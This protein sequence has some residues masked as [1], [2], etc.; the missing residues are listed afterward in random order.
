MEKVERVSKTVFWDD[1]GS[2][3]ELIASPV[4]ALP[5]PLGECMKCTYM[6]ML[7]AIFTLRSVVNMQ[8][9]HIMARL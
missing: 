8:A 7:V 3:D 5:W 2:L 9:A 6:E 4:L 1:P